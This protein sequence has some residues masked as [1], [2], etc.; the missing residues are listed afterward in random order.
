MRYIYNINLV[1]FLLFFHHMAFSQL[2]WSYI[3][4][5]ERGGSDV[6]STLAYT[7]TT[8]L[9]N[10]NVLG[11]GLN[12]WDDLDSEA[13]DNGIYGLMTLLSPKGELIKD[14]LMEPGLFNYPIYVKDIPEDK[15]FYT[16]NWGLQSNSW[17]VLNWSYDLV[18]KSTNSI[19]LD[20]DG[21][22]DEF[23]LI[24]YAKMK[25]GNIILN[26]FFEVDEY[27]YVSMMMILD[28]KG[29]VI[30]EK[31]FKDVNVFNIFEKQDQS[32]YWGIGLDLVDFDNDFNIKNVRKDLF[33]DKDEINVLNYKEKVIVS[34]ITHNDDDTENWKLDIMDSKLNLLNS[35][36]LINSKYFL[37]FNHNSIDIDDNGYIYLG[38]SDIDDDFKF[39]IQLIKLD[40][41]FDVVWKKRMVN[42]GYEFLGFNLEVNAKGEILIG[43]LA[44][45]LESDNTGFGIILNVNNEKSSSTK[46]KST[47]LNLLTLYPNPAKNSI[48]IDSERDLTGTNVKIVDVS[49]KM[50]YSTMLSADHSIDVGSLEKGLYIAKIDHVISGYVPIPF[51]KE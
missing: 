35:I 24:R 25:N 40:E 37:S 3:N 1:F 16:V 5:Y 7:G 6:S 46:D 31:V 41:E 49:G 48:W 15:S 13:S 8:I 23:K 32:G 19:V 47:S 45:S 33:I 39:G 9:S 10:G 51:I 18:L 50:I 20:Y 12:V 38:I 14:T 36:D 28:K 27:D 22:I 17:Y 30:A 34:Y 26:C 42:Q 4:F 11:C 44:Y 43:G 2:N 29:N 21:D